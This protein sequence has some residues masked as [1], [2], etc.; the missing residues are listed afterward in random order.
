MEKSFSPA[1]V[2]KRH[3]LAVYNVEQ[4]APKGWQKKCA[5]GKGIHTGDYTNNNLSGKC[6]TCDITFATAQQFYEHLDDCVLSKVMEKERAVSDN[7]RNLAQAMLED[8]DDPTLRSRE[9][10][11]DEEGEERGDV[12][13]I[14]DGG[15]RREK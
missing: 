14:R 3:L 13:E 8:I 12:N 4:T 15:R 5:K 9:D 2:F 7:E 11:K 10:E 6:S 1:D